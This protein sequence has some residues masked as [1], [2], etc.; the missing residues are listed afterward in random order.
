V[1]PEHSNVAE[2]PALPDPPAIDKP[3]SRMPGRPWLAS[4]NE[5]TARDG[6][7]W[8]KPKSG[9][10]QPS[11]L[12]TPL[13]IG[14]GSIECELNLNGANRISRRF[15]ARDAGFR[16][17]VSRTLAVLTKN[18]SEGKPASAT[19]RIAK[20]NFK[21]EADE[22]HPVRLNLNNDEAT[23]QV[24]G[25]T[26]IGVFK[27]VTPLKSAFRQTATLESAMFS[28]RRCRGAQRAKQPG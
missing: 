24:N 18:P 16:L 21:L 17:V 13:N 10:E 9:S 7:L 15:G 5:W 6:G 25:Q 1:K 12:R 28:G 27:K 8:A 19:E 4:A 26:C 11:S 3:W 2:L 14:D 23:I 22:W 20:K